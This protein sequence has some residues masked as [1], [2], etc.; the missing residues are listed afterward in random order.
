MSLQPGIFDHIWFPFT[1]SQDLK[2]FP[3]IVIE[4]GE[5]IYIYDTRGNCYMDAIGS[6]WVSVLGHNHP[7]I[8]RAVSGQ[9]NKLEHVLMAGCIA[10]PTLRLSGLL[11]GMAP[12]GLDRIFYSD[13]GSTSVEVA[14]KMAIQYWANKGEN[15]KEFVSL[16]GGYH[17]DTLGAMS[18]GGIPS[19]HDLFHDRFKKQLFVNSPYCYR[20]PCGLD[21]TIC[22]AQCMDSLET[23]LNAQSASI[24]A[25]IIEPMVQAAVGMRVYPAK[26]LTRISELCKI[27]D[28]LLIA[29]EVAMGFGRTGRLFACEHAGIVPDIMCIAKGLTGGY[30]PMAAT[31]TSEEIYREFCGDYSSGREFQ[32]GHTFT[33]NP[34]AAAAACETLTILKEENIPDSLSEKIAFFQNGLH[35]FNDFDCVGDVRSIGMV[36]AI[37]LVKNKKTKEKLPAEKRLPFFIARKALEHGLLIRPLGDVLYFIPAYIITEEEMDLM[38]QTAKKAIKDVAVTL[39]H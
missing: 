28:V 35:Q 2:D 5:G 25:C 6:W 37:E 32:H 16:I 10:E 38:L 8:S 24:A 39:N 9:I 22:I 12:K 1:C 3:P 31:L 14:L 11:A 15:K 29:D 20:C 26:V 18:V 19:Y 23:L 34:L 27:H 30:I 33:G 21:N 13:N 4:R 36:G 7:R 17:G